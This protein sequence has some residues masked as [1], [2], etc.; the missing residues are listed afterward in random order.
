MEKLQELKEIFEVGKKY[1]IYRISEMMAMTSKTE[2]TV[3]EIE[4]GRIIFTKRNGRKRFIIS[5]QSRGDQFSPMAPFTAGIFQDW[6]QPIKCDTEFASGVMRGNACYNFIG[7]P[8]EI[9]VWIETGQLN[10]FFD[11]SKVLAI[12]DQK[13]CSGS[14]NEKVVFPDEVQPGQHAVIDRIL[15]AAS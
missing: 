11:K 9:Q 7:I 14:N 8:L 10:P 15:A 5:F 4:D 1:T 3:K 12:A 6:D 13:S 2:I